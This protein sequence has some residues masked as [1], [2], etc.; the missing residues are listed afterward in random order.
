M[1]VDHS[2]AVETRVVSIVATRSRS[3]CEGHGVLGSESG[4][5]GS[6]LKV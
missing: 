6:G 1:R 2:S 3:T 5:W 4:V